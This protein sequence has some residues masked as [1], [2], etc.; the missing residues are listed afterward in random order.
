MA[1]GIFCCILGAEFLMVDHLVLRSSKKPQEK[2]GVV[3]QIG[4]A[5]QANAVKQQKVYV[6][7]DWMPWTLITGGAFALIYSYRPKN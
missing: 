5:K 7:K 1:V 2:P 3:R 6:P 4:F